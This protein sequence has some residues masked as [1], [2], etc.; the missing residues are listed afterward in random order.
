MELRESTTASGVRVYEYTPSTDRLRY[1]L[2]L[3]L[4]SASRRIARLLRDR[5]DFDC[6][7]QIDAQ[8]RLEKFTYDEEGNYIRTEVEPHFLSAVQL[9]NSATLFTDIGD[10]IQQIS[11]SFESYL[12]DGSGWVLHSVRHVFLRVYASEAFSAV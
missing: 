12:S 2:L 4:A 6:K 11:I 8:L 5:R 3:S 10:A 1:D 9:Y 7:Y